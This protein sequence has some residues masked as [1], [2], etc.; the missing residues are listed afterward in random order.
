MLTLLKTSE[1]TGLQV[2]LDDEWIPVDPPADSYIINLGANRTL[3]HEELDHF[4]LPSTS[5]CLSMMHS[6]MLRRT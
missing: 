2:K 3:L 6:S 4:S 1:V 5:G